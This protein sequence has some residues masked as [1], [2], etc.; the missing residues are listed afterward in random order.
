MTQANDSRSTATCDRCEMAIPTDAD[1][2]PVCNYRPAGRN[3]LAMRVGEYFFGTVIVVSVLVFV[4]GVTGLTPVIPEI[5]SRVAI[6]TP[7]TTGI[8]AFFFYYLYQKRRTT[9]TDSEVFD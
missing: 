1:R 8:S 5:M 9:P 3:P 4:G 6:V 2:C 7:Y